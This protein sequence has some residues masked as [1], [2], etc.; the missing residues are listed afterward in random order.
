MS[1]KV[2]RIRIGIY[3]AWPVFRKLLGIFVRN[4]DVAGNF[5][6]KTRENV[7]PISDDASAGGNRSVKICSAKKRA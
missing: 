6:A 5:L 7:A 1:K 4:L 3:L 2:L